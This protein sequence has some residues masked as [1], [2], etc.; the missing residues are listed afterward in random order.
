MRLTLLAVL[1]C[2][3]SCAVPEAQRRLR[4][5]VDAAVSRSDGAAGARRY[6]EHRRAGGED[7]ERA[8]SALALGDLRDALRASDPRARLAAVRA[9]EELGEPTLLP[10][11]P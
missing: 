1:F 3:T 6:L 4:A 7:D 2:S 5:D 11:L 8:L 9:A 10:P